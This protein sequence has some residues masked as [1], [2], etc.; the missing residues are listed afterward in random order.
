MEY[1]VVLLVEIDLAHE[2]LLRG[3]E[4]SDLA[5]PLG[6]L[7]FHRFLKVFKGL[8]H[9]K[10]EST[11]AFSEFAPMIIIAFSLFTLSLLHLP[12]NLVVTVIQSRL[13]LVSILGGLLFD[14]LEVG[15]DLVDV[16]PKLIT[17]F[18]NFSYQGLNLFRHQ[19]LL[20]S[21]AFLVYKLHCVLFI[22]LEPLVTIFKDD[23]SND[24]L[25]ESLPDALFHRLHCGRLLS[26][27][28]R[29]LGDGALFLFYCLNNLLL[30]FNH[31]WLTL[32]RCL[33][34]L[35]GGL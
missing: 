13:D 26:S 9:Q 30:R 1:E 18:L 33:I 10:F 31:S 14:G 8:L 12:M 11:L 23:F 19:F 15:N 27:L 24:I 4:V 29:C 17:L 34:G 5:H 21:L 25:V 16:F 6:L 32:T 2:S 35:C 22:F 20:E 3:Y 7:H 28:P